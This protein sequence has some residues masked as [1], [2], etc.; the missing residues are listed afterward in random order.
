MAELLQFNTITIQFTPPSFFHPH[1]TMYT[2]GHFTVCLLVVF[3]GKVKT[4]MYLR[5]ESN[6]H[7]KMLVLQ[8]RISGF[9]GSEHDAEKR[10][11]M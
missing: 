11:T 2:L 4:T 1:C 6:Y 7:M 3:V 10:T 8:Q 9:A 5:L